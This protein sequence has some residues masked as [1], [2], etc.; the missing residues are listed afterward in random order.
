MDHTAGHVPIPPLGAEGPPA[1][2][3]TSFSGDP[4]TASVAPLD[5]C[6]VAKMLLRDCGVLTPSAQ[7]VTPPSL[8]QLLLGRGVEQEEISA[9]F[10][11][12]CPQ[13]SAAAGHADRYLDGIS[14]PQL[15]DAMQLYRDHAR[16]HYSPV[17]VPQPHSKSFVSVSNVTLDG[18]PA[19][20]IPPP[21]APTP[22]PTSPTPPPTSPTPPP[23]AP[24]PPPAAPT[25]RA[26]GLHR[27]PRV[28][29]VKAAESAPPAHEPTASKPPA[30]APGLGAPSAASTPLPPDLANQ[31]KLLVLG[32]ERDWDGSWLQPLSF[33]EVECLSYGLFQDKGGPCGLLAVLQAFTLKHLLFCDEDPVVD[34]QLPAQVKPRRVR[35][36]VAGLCEIL[37]A[38]GDAQR[39]LV[40]MPSSDGLPVSPSTPL[41]RL[42]LVEF[43]SE[44]QLSEFL[45]RNSHQLMDPA[46]SGVLCAL[47]SVLLSRGVELIR[48]EMDCASEPLIG[49]FGY[50]AQE[51]LNLMLTGRATSNMFDGDK[52]IGDGAESMRLRGVQAQ[53]CIGQL[54][55][56]E[57]YGNMQVGEH[58]KHPRIPIW[59]VCS[60]SHFS[61]MFCSTSIG[62]NVEPPPTVFEMFYYDGLGR[63]D[64]TIRWTIEPGVRDQD[65]DDDPPLELVIGTRWPKPRVDWNGA[66]V[67]L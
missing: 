52:T 8:I 50:C 22:P 31:L 2:G 24:T 53:S 60:E 1:A 18:P 30:H 45:Q 46:A 38:A 4:L 13:P 41:E 39:A 61:V 25:P 32:S 26:G 19:A 59:V 56:F 15:A 9:L 49:K 55:L 64:E 34:I 35:A 29:R 57:A 62:H 10:S 3:H 27:S 51:L 67:L 14:E 47:C 54:T 28:Q 5:N 48:S 23:T 66:E 44:A 12:M 6:F 43:E 7:S 58:L 40:V 20:P 42:E 11:H 21:A 17:V 33:S 65:V 36:L 16:A 63:Q 37:W